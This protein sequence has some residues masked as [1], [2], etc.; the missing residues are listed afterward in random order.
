MAKDYYDVLGVSRDA[1]KEEIR[2]AYK[3]LAKK[4]HPDINK[5]AGS[6]KKFKEI[7][8]AAAVLGDDKKRQMYDQYGTADFNGSAGPG[9]GFDFSGMGGDFDFG[10]IFDSFFGGGSPFGGRQR[11]N[12]PRKGSDLRYDIEI[13]L[14]DVVSG[15][16]KHIVIPRHETC[17]HCKG[18]GANSPDDLKTCDTCN[19]TGRVTRT[20]RTPFGLFQSTGTCPNCRG[21]GKTIANLCDECNGSGQIEHERKIKVDIPKGVEEGN[22]LRMSGEGEAGYK[23]GPSG[24][25]FVVVHVRNHKIFDRKGNDLF[26]EVPISFVVA[27]LGGSIK[28]PTID[29]N[30]SLKIPAGTQSNTYFKMKGKG[31]PQLRGSSIGNQMVKVIVYTPQNLNQKQKETLK[32]FGKSI[33]DK[34]LP[35]KTFFDKVKESLFE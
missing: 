5:E 35:K 34:I 12:G 6:E 17:S 29:G 7:N 2:K 31:C 22:I 25:L 15:T 13:E 20:Q 1:K 30:A 23:G 27:A 16:T 26:I 28:V 14:E 21:E 33:G 18:S 32:K 24:D 8:E 10:D 4:Y 19:G 3:K 9:A 11:R